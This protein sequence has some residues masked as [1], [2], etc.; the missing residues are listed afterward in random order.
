MKTCTIIGGINGVG[1]SS[2]LGVLRAVRTDLGLVVDE[3]ENQKTPAFLKK[4]TFPF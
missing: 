3:K 2:L 1:K 4:Q